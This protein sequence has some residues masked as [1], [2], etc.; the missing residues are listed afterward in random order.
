MDFTLRFPHKNTSTHFSSP[1]PHHI[2]IRYFLF[3]EDNSLYVA[4]LS[5]FGVDE[6]SVISAKFAWPQPEMD[7]GHSHF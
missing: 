3:L 6:D 1:H 4:C 2:P 5:S 7:G